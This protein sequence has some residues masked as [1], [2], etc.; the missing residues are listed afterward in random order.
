MEGCAG[1]GLAGG[2]KA[3][4]WIGA[5]ACGG[6]GTAFGCVAGTAAGV[7]GCCGGRGLKIFAR[8]NAM[9]SFELVI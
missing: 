5:I 3:W 9:M 1:A 6:V 2:M 4:G 7:I 8:V